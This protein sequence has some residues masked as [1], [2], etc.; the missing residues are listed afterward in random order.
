M[1]AKV[2][3]V[4]A[5]TDTE[6][7]LQAQQ[8]MTDEATPKYQVLEDALQKLMDL[9]ISL[10]KAE[11]AQLRTVIIIVIITAALYSNSLSIAISKSIEK[12]FNELKDRFITLQ[13]EI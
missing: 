13:R 10:G 2:I 7:S 12:P 9:N 6:K 11:R 5:T 4:G 3:E 8:M 1:D